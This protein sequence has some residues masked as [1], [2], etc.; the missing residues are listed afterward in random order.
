MHDLQSEI[1]ISCG[2]KPEPNPESLM[3][4]LEQ[5]KIE[6][7]KSDALIDLL[8]SKVSELKAF[9][10][11]DAKPEDL[12]PEPNSIIQDLKMQNLIHNKLNQRLEFILK[13]LEKA[14]R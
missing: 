6:N 9:D 10:T 2:P 12:S 3:M 11:T 1:A 13:H 5:R 7:N 8:S 14:I 4:I